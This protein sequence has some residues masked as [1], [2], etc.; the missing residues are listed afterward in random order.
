MFLT[1]CDRESHYMNTAA[2]TKDSKAT[3]V[4]SAQYDDRIV[5]KY[6]VHLIGWPL[7]ELKNPSNI[8]SIGD[9]NKVNKALADGTCRWVRL[10][11]DEFDEYATN[12]EREVSAGCRKAL[13]H[14]STNGHKR[15][16]ND[17]QSAAKKRLRTEN[18]NDDN[19]HQM[20]SLESILQF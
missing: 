17:E 8:T 7:E 16:A 5:M 3:M 18:T 12:L 20:G 11:N 2:I 19:G 13:N 14:I 15:K 4:Y 10:T 9:L 1:N 6:G